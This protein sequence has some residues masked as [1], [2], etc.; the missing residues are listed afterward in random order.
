MLVMNP[1]S[2]TCI[3]S[4]MLYIQQR[5]YCASFFKKAKIR[6]YANHN[7]KKILNNKQFRKIMIPLFPIN[8]FSG[9]KTNSTENAEHVKTEMKT[10]EVLNSFFTNIVSNLKIPQYSDFDPI[11][12]SV[13]DP[14][15]KVIVKYKNQTLKMK[16]LIQ[17]LK[18]SQFSDIPAKI[19]KENVDVFAGFLSTSVNSST[20]SSLSPSCPKFADVTSLHKKRRKGAKGNYR[21][22][23]IS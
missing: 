9:D 23:S 14:T 15:L 3:E 12:Q 10:A 11:V 21:P 1:D 5:N 8:Q 17:K 16:L 4:R 20:K 18:A 13:E 19:I 22:V 6:Y 7:E 2:P